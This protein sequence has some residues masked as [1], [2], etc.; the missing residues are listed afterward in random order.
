MS[1]MDGGKPKAGPMRPIPDI[2]SQRVAPRSPT[3]LR[4]LSRRA[5][6]LAPLALG[7]C[8]TI[9]GWFTTKKVP[10]PGKREPLGGPRRG[11]SPDQG[12]PAV[13]LPPPVRDM[14]WPQAGGDPTHLMGHLS[15]NDVLK[16]AWSADVGEGGGKRRQILA[17]PVVANGIVYTMNSEFSGLRLHARH[18]RARVAHTDRE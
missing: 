11:F 3:A 6:L 18:G 9:E 17:Q 2:A 5:A 7:G 12:T 15:A 16:Q 8:E 13:T 14:A 4:A 10:L 1:D